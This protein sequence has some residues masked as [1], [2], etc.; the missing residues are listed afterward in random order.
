MLAR[1]VDV[2]LNCKY[3]VNFFH[4]AEYCAANVTTL[5]LMKKKTY[6]LREHLLFHT[7]YKFQDGRLS[8][9]LAIHGLVQSTGAALRT[10]YIRDLAE[11]NRTKQ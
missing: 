4:I 9:R 2:K 11:R 5:Q 8:T 10:D 6:P 3:S 7:W 1:A